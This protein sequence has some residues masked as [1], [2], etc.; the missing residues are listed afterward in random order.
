MRGF[1]PEH[2]LLQEV[3]PTLDTGVAQMCAR[4]HH[5]KALFHERDKIE[6]TIGRG[7]GLN[8]DTDIRDTPSNEVRNF[9]VSGGH[10]AD[11]Q[12]SFAPAHKLTQD[13][14]GT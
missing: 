9:G 13:L 7:H 8:G 3:K 11:V 1:D 2:P 14:L 10:R 5:V 6:R 12:H 4:D